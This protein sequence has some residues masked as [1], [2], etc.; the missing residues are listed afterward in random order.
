MSRTL[1]TAA[2]L[3]VL[4][5]TTA[6]C[7]ALPFLGYLPTVAQLAPPL[8]SGSRRSERSNAPADSPD[9]PVAAQPTSP[10][11]GGPVQVANAGSAS[12]AAALPQPAPAN[13]SRIDPPKEG[14]GAGAM[15]M[16]PAELAYPGTAQG[17]AQADGTIALAEN[18]VDLAADYKARAV[19]DLI[20]VKVS[21]SISGASSAQ[22]TLADKRALQSAAPNLLTG[23]ESLAAHNPLLNLGSLINTSS[24]N[25]TA[26]QGNMTAGDTFTANIS[27]LVVAMT[28]AGDLVVK[29]EREVH[30]NGE[31]DTVRVSGIVRIEDLDSNNNVPSYKVANLH[32]SLAGKGLIR[33]KQG[34]GAGSRLF[35]WLWPF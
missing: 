27:A 14:P 24:Q 12:G 19:G 34:V 28:P 10:A 2:A 25:N 3:L 29:G 20:T 18:D 32:V 6:G 26:G 21:E 22:T 1:G 31:T 17:A 5:A 7:A 23:T 15:L 35:D 33:D 4:A 8:F 13:P 9:P 16:A 30:I 11:A